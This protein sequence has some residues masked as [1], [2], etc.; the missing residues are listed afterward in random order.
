[1]IEAATHNK[2]V[3]SSTLVVATVDA[4]SNMLKTAMIGDSGYMILRPRDAAALSYDLVYKSNEQQHSFN[5]PF[6]I[7]SRGDSPHKALNN[8]HE[9]HK[10]DLV[11]L[12]S[13]GLFDNLFSN[14]IVDLVNKYM[15]KNEF[16]S[17]G[18]A[19]YLS[20]ETY[21]VSLD[22]DV[23]S[24]FADGARKAKMYFKGGKSDDITIVVGKVND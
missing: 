18:L 1:M 4:N 19:K 22:P 9:I 14:Q 11:I 17:Q 5:F 8:E 10:N 12:G 7:G 15:A 13:D 16:S 20:E 21:K 24:P 3:G 23:I 2:E 6:Q